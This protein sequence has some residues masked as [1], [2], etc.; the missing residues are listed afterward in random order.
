MGMLVITLG[1]DNHLSANERGKITAARQH[2]AEINVPYAAPVRNLRQA[3]TM[4]GDV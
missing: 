2:F 4:V 3:L 1:C